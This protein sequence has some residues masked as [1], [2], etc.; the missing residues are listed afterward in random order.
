M[1][2]DVSLKD[3]DKNQCKACQ[4]FECLDKYINKYNANCEVEQ[5]GL[6]KN[7][8]NEKF[9]CNEKNFVVGKN[10]GRKSKKQIK[11]KKQRKSRRC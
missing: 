9:V 5:P 10:G 2:C 6:T 1:P 8:F 11:S 7:W 4:R 3:I